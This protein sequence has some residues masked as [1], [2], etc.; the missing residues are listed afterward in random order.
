MLGF[1]L[2]GVGI[3]GGG[4]EIELWSYHP[5]TDSWQREVNL[6]Y[7]PYDSLI[8]RSVFT[9]GDYAYGIVGQKVY[10]FYKIP[11]GQ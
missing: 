6:P 4:S 9:I 2:W 1:S 8:F 10:Q 11:P 5:S 7:F 3:V